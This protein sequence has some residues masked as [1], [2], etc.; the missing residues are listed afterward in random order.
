MFVAARRI[1]LVDVTRRDRLG[2]RRRAHHRFQIELALVRGDRELLEQQPEDRDERNAKPVAAAKRHRQWQLGRCVQ[3]RAYRA[4]EP[5]EPQPRE[6]FPDA[7][8]EPEP[9]ANRC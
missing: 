6:K 2:L 7:V 4:P 3:G 1:G 8:P 9:G 5:W